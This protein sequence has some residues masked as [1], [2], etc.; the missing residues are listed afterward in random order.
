MEKVPEK[1]KTPKQEKEQEKGGDF[2][3][4]DVHIDLKLL[5]EWKQ[6]DSIISNTESL[7]GYSTPEVTIGQKTTTN[8]IPSEGTSGP[9]M[10]QKDVEMIPE[11]PSN[12]IVLHV[13]EIPPLDVFYSP[14]HRVVIKRQRKKRKLDQSSLLPT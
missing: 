7:Q 4:S 1:E 13:E 9:P 3:D 14:K 5:K 6:F 10:T 8:T 12:E 2:I 11:N